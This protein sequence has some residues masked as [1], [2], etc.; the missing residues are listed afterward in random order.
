MNVLTSVA[1]LRYP[2]RELSDQEGTPERGLAGRL[3]AL[4]WLPAAFYAAGAATAGDPPWLADPDGWL[5][6]AFLAAGGVPLVRACGRVRRMGYPGAAWMA[7]GILAPATVA[8]SVYMT[9]HGA[10]WVAAC[11][12]ATSLPAW[13]PYGLGCLNRRTR[14]RN[15]RRIVS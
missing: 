14:R 5:Y 6:L 1:A 10:L 8:V 3:G 4:M 11:A 7:F 12:A 13:L 2:P 15:S 9:P